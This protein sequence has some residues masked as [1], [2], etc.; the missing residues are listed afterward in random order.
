MRDRGTHGP[1]KDKEVKDKEV[2]HSK[3][4]AEALL[5]RGIGRRTLH[6]TEDRLTDAQATLFARMRDEGAQICV[7]GGLGLAPDDPTALNAFLSARLARGREIKRSPDFLKM[8]PVARTTAVRS[9]AGGHIALTGSHPDTLHHFYGLSERG[10][11]ALTQHQAA[12]R[13][14][15]SRTAKPT[16]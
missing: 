6:Q 10:L 14:A 3:T 5:L 9:M 15:P 7:T 8:T 4:Q 2:Q 11:A 12:R 1:M 16:E 13:R